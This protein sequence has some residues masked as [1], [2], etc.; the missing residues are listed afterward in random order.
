MSRYVDPN[1]G[2]ASQPGGVVRPAP[3][4]KPKPTEAP[5]KVAP[6]AAS[7]PE[8]EPEPEPTSEPEPGPEPE[9]EPTDGLDEKTRD[10]LIEIAGKLQVTGR[11]QM[12]RA[13]LLAAIRTSS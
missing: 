11:H 6:K 7:A 10:E 5:K 1:S 8:P 12:S 4:P 9:P 3:K 13:D 2:A